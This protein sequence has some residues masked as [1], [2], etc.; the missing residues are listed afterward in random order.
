MYVVLVFSLGLL[1][2]IEIRILG[3]EMWICPYTHVSILN[4]FFKDHK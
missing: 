1:Y 4:T 2:G 3:I